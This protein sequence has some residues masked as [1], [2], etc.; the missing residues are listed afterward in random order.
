MTEDIERL[1]NEKF[2]KAAQFFLANRGFNQEIGEEQKSSVTYLVTE[3]LF[4]RCASRRI[5]EN[6]NFS[7]VN[8]CQRW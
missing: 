6:F 2:T 8:A 1:F 5:W 3:K 7:V 4:T